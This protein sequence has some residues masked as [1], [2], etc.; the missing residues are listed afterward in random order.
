MSMTRQEQ[1]DRIAE[2]DN[3]IDGGS[4][5]MKSTGTPPQGMSEWMIEREIRI[6]K[7]SLPEDLPPIDP[8]VGLDA[9]QEEELP[10][11]PPAAEP[12]LSLAEKAAKLAN[13]VF[14][15][16]PPTPATDLELARIYAE[17]A[18]TQAINELTA[19]LEASTAAR[20]PPVKR[21]ATKKEKTA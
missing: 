1:L 10:E 16:I 8:A 5:L 2:L 17:L 7:L 13:S 6:R 12:V 21:A 14:W 20:R 4:S 9:E 3:L 18:H 15:Q 19:A 11:Q